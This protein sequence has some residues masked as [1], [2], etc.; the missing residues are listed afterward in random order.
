MVSDLRYR[1]APLYSTLLRGTVADDGTHAHRPTPTKRKQGN[2]R[3][4]GN[5]HKQIG[6]VKQGWVVSLLRYE[7]PSFHVSCVSFELVI[8]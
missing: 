3:K 5:E 8:A 2:E 4:K 1:D 6:Y 7:H